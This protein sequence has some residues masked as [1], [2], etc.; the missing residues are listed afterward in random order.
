MSAGVHVQEYGV[1]FERLLF[2]LL[3]S[4]LNGSQLFPNTC[5][6]YSWYLGVVLSCALDKNG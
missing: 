2:T 6:T 4:Y 5:N 1:F 3:F